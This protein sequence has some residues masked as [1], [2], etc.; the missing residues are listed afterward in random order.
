MSNLL[1]ASLQTL[2]TFDFYPDGFKNT[3]LYWIHLVRT[4]ALTSE[5]QEQLKQ[6]MNLWTNETMVALALIEL[7]NGKQD[8]ATMLH[9]MKLSGLGHHK[10]LYG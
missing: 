8:A 10:I 7:S 4:N 3:I 5:H 9:Q 1:L 6:D 2:A